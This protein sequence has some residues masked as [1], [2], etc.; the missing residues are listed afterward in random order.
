MPTETL[1][2]LL[3]EYKYGLAG[4]RALQT[5]TGGLKLQKV[6]WYLH[7]IQVVLWFFP[8][9][10][11]IPFHGVV[12]VWTSPYYLG[13]VYGVL[14]S[15]VVLLLNGVVWWVLYK[16]GDNEEEIEAGDEGEEEENIPS[17]WSIQAVRFLFHQGRPIVSIPFHGLFT[18]LLCY[19]AFLLLNPFTLRSILPIPAVVVVFILGWVSVCSAHY[20]LLLHP[21]HEV[22]IHRPSHRDRLLLRYIT[23]PFHI[24][25][26]AA[27]FVPFRYVLLYIEIS[28]VF[29]CSIAYKCP[30]CLHPILYCMCCTVCCV[31]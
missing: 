24:I 1:P 25:L 30:Q 26:I 8:L 21:P 12:F 13:T 18:G 6:P 17:C 22:A 29:L 19:A 31:Y 28:T 14:S 11:S 9:L 3:N 27:L 5:I 20:S 15:L 2:P 4:R 7:M 10:I 16:A 23:R